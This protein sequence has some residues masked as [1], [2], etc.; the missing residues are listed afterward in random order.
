MWALFKMLTGCYQLV[1]IA[2]VVVLRPA[3]LSQ[4]VACCVGSRWA[5]LVLGYVPRPRN[6]RIAQAL[7]VGIALQARLTGL[8]DRYEWGLRLWVRIKCCHL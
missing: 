8:S 4:A 6:R 3:Q 2:G 7:D 5:G 1:L